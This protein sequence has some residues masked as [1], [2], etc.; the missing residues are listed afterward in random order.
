MDRI[1]KLKAFLQENPQDSFLQ[2]ALALEYVKTGDMQQ[3]RVQWEQLLQR[4]SGYVGSYYHLA[5]LLVQQGATD[6]AIS[7]YEKG[8]SVARAAGDAHALAELRG[9]YE[10][11][12]L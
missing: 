11:L 9:A 5:Q 7:W 1:Q 6:E 3:A 4:D 8:M 2:H 12:T 10:E